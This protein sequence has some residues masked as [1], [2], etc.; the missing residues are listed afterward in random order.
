MGHRRKWLSLYPVVPL[1]GVS[2]YDEV[3]KCFFEANPAISG[4][5]LH[6]FLLSGYQVN[7]AASELEQWIKVVRLDYASPLFAYDDLLRGCYNVQPTMD[8]TCFCGMLADSGVD[9]NIPSMQCWMLLQPPLFDVK[10]TDYNTF[11]AGWE[12]DAYDDLLRGCCVA[13]PGINA[14]RL[15]VAL[16]QSMGVKCRLAHMVHWMNSKPG[17]CKVTRQ[18]KKKPIAR[19]LFVKKMKKRSMVRSHFGSRRE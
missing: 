12:I 9:C 4:A 13:M 15:R 16:M 1:C 10:L 11:I 6:A 2:D 5:V 8:A 19:K 3:L 18:K 7:V 14:I 17:L